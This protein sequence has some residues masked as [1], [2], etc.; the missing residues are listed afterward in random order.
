VRAACPRIVR[1]GRAAE[2]PGRHGVTRR[3]GLRLRITA[4]VRTAHHRITAIAAILHH[5]RIRRRAVRVAAAPTAIPAA[6]PTAEAAEDFMVVE[7]AA[8]VV[9]VDTINSGL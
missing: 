2:I 5:G 4:D 3:T 7:A 9:A 8:T 1:L 6:A